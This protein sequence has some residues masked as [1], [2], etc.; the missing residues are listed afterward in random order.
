MPVQGHHISLLGGEAVIYHHLASAGLVE[1]GNLD[2]VAERGVAVAQNDVDVFDESVVADAIIGNIIVNAF[3]AAVVSYF[4]IVQGD[5]IEAGVLFHTSGQRELLVEGAEADVARET[6]REYVVGG[7]EL[8]DEDAFPFGSG[9]QLFFE[10]DD[11]LCC[12]VTIVHFLRFY[13]AR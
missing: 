9:A 10:L 2:A 11:F 13:S 5:V 1:D 6:G 4:D 12:K 8:G 3:Y 7:E